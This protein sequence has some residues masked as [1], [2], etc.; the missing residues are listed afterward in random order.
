MLRLWRLAT[1]NKK[2]ASAFASPAVSGCNDVRRTR[3]QAV[4]RVLCVVAVSARIQGQLLMAPHANKQFN[5]D[6]KQIRGQSRGGGTAVLQSPNGPMMKLL[7]INSHARSQHLPACTQA[8][9]HGHRCTS[10]H[11]LARPITIELRSEVLF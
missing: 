6:R 2:V 8:L 5:G 7:H 1:S 10:T 4:H 9:T 11:M 3:C